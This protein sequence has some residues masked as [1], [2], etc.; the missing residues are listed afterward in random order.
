[1]SSGRQA[2]AVPSARAERRRN[3]RESLGV[4]VYTSVTIAIVI[5]ILVI[6]Y[7]A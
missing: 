7:L 1:M 5:A 3:M 2:A 6:V 4:V